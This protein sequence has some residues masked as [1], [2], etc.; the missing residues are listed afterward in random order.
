MIKIQNIALGLDESE[1]LLK[2]K[3]GKILR[4]SPEGIK[5]I[6]IE[7]ESIDARKKPLK[8]IYTVLL[9][10][11]QEKEVLRKNNDPQVSAY[12]S[13]EIRILPL[14]EEKMVDPPV[15]VGL[16]PAGLFAGLKL[17]REGYRP[18]IL[19]QGEPMAERDRSVD[20]FMQMGILNPKSNIQFGEGGAGAYSDGKL[21]TR[22]KDPRV[23]DVLDILIHH[24][25]PD[26]IAYQAKPHVGTDLLKGIVVD[27]RKEI[28]ALGGKI[29]FNTTFT[30]LIQSRGKLTGIKTSEGDL[31]CQILL[32][33]LGH[34]ARETYEMLFATGVAMEAK[35]MAVGVRIENLQ[36]RIDEAQYGLAY[37]HPRLKP[38]EYALKHKLKNGRGVYSFCMCPGG[39][40]VPA[41]SEEGMLAVNGM[42]YHD[43]A[44]TN[45][46]SAIVVSVT[47]RDYGN[48]PLDGLAFQRRMEKAC[49]SATGNYHASVQKVEDFF[50]GKVTSDFTEVMPS[51][52]PGVMP[53]NLKEILPY[54]VSESLDAGLHE[55][56]RKVPGFTKHGA[57]M[58][59]VE[60][61]TSSPLRILRGSNLESISI[62]GLYPVGEGAG[63]AGGIVSSAVDGLKVAEAIISKYQSFD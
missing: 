56:E 16:G 10:V 23:H 14:G 32:L 48:H 9:E 35:P 26:E 57:V 7:K 12:T 2:E 40:V 1:E 50:Q 20:H 47:P 54:F 36:W 28:I 62:E 15:I 25:A 21:T 58:T 38:A 52:L 37:K 24:G 29:H 51:Y 55:F 3:A 46:N 49:F 60:T 31:S 61:R 18:I 8:F 13:P 6:K 17:A 22:I 11:N 19:E 5:S 42:S 43:R 4:I 53:G 45:A 39:T 41:S 27:M 33:A 44:G 34:S 30:G 63:Y 59:G